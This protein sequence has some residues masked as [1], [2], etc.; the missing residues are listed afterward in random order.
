MKNP[1]YGTSLKTIIYKITDIV[2]AKKYMYIDSDMLILDNLNPLFDTLD[3]LYPNTFLAVKHSDR[4]SLYTLGESILSTN[5]GGKANDVLILGLSELEQNSTCVIN[6]GFFVTN[7]RTMLSINHTIETLLPNI[8]IWMMDCSGS[9]VR[10]E[11]VLLSAL[12]RTQSCVYIDDTYNL[13]LHDIN[14]L[15]KITID[16]NRVYYK[17]KPAKILHFT[18]NTKI[19]EYP[20]YLELINNH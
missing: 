16:E 17:N 12:A 3:Y 11:A 10:E 4:S 14:V 18:G 6:S 5:F 9:L 1:L 7:D 15:N 2:W 13:Q 20:K 19:D 8:K